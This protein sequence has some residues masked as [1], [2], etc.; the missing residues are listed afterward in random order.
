[1][2]PH[3]WEPLGME[4]A[5]HAAPSDAVVCGR[6]GAIMAEHFDRRLR[7]TGGPTTRWGIGVSPDDRLQ[8]VPDVS[9]DCD[10]EMARS[11]IDG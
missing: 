2:T 4:T 3:R 8:Q 1:M 7:V 6:C 9:E 11:V 10:E 5:E